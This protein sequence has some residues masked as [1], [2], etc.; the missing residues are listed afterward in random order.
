M[1]SPFGRFGKL[2]VLQVFGG[3]IH[4]SLLQEAYNSEYK[5]N[6]FLVFI[7]KEWVVC[8]NGRFVGVG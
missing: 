5:H 7:A 3:A 1:D 2:P 8:R 6:L 4:S